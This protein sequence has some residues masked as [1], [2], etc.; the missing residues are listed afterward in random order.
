MLEPVIAS[1]VA[2]VILGEVLN[3]AQLTGGVL[4]LIGVGLAET[5]RTAAAPEPDPGPLP[6]GAIAV[7]PNL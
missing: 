7:P 2:W 6:A 3:V 4:V 1:A 5:A